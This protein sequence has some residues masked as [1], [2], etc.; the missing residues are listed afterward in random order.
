MPARRKPETIDEFLATVGKGQRAA[1]E[2]LRR[3]I[4]AAVPQAEEC[5]TYGI[6]A[7]RLDGKP[8]AGFGAGKNHCTLFPMSGSTVATLAAEL[9]GYETSKGAIR[10]APGKPLPAALVRKV[11]RARIAEIAE[12]TKKTAHARPKTRRKT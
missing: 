4:R 5:I 3:T 10:F 9:K 8:I 2:N 7:F 6:A 11:I 1:L 12:R